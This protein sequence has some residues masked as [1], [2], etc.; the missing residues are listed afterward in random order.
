MR[1]GLNQLGTVTHGVAG[2]TTELQS[3]FL[4]LQQ[5]VA[6]E[7][8][9][10][11]YLRL[12]IRYRE[13]SPHT[14][15][16]AIFYSLYALAH[17]NYEV[18]LEYGLQAF[19]RRRVNLVVWRVLT[20]CYRQMHRYDYAAYFA[21]LIHRFCPGDVDLPMEQAQLQQVFDMFSLG[22]GIA[23]YAPIATRRAYM[24]EQGAAL[25]EDI[26]VGE[27]LPAV[28]QDD[29]ESY[30][31]G[32]YPHGTTTSLNM[33]HVVKKLR[34]D[35]EFIENTCVG[36]IFDLQRSHTT[37]T[38]ELHPEG[39]CIL[40]VATTAAGQR[41]KFDFDGQQKEIT[42]PGRWNYS[43]Y[44][45]DKD[46]RISSEQDMVVGQP[47]RLGHSPKRRKVIL[48]ILTDA[49]CWE[50]VGPRFA[51]LMPNTCRFFQKGIVF[52]KHYSVSE[53]TFPSL[54]TLE[55]GLY[56]A[57]S[58]VFNERCAVGIGPEIRTLAERMHEAGYYC[59]NL[60]SDGGNVYDGVTRGYDRLLIKSYDNKAYEGVSRTIVQLEALSECDQ[61]IFLH[62]DD[63]HSWPMPDYRV[64][65]ATQAHLPLGDR[66]ATQEYK[67]SVNIEGNI[68]YY[69]EG[70][71]HYIRMMD[72]NL[73][74]LYEYI[75]ANYSES[76]YVVQLYSDHGTGIYRLGTATPVPLL[77]SDYSNHAALMLRGSGIPARGR[78]SDE[79]T[80]TVDFYD[81][82]LHNAGL[83]GHSADGNLP[84][85]LGGQKRDF[86]AS[87]V[88]YPGQKYTLCLRTER[89][90]MILQ[91]R[92]PLRNDGTVNLDGAEC[93]ILN[94]DGSYG[95][96]DTPERRDYYMH[97]AG[98]IARHV[99]DQGIRWIQ[100]S[101]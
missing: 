18:A 10:D 9:D 19:A 52:D 6:Q 91:S 13:L 29:R 45:I 62:I 38:E 39:I 99:H 33:E 75:E 28:W 61:F 26:F 69:V 14:E 98:Y 49:L 32:I 64:G 8:Y 101:D 97:L 76:E 5:M 23:N 31:V 43:Y 46:T 36:T 79:L 78:V 58:Q 92:E 81:I 4:K 89:D 88:I 27:Y 47:I 73:E 15:H 93:R 100:G 41:L 94:R 82:T 66:L 87:Y 42:L 95:D 30:F 25:R 86:T 84:A 22:S 63:P 21:G 3:L 17:D 54:A 51:E 1:I 57:E 70:V 24:A 40:P 35:E 71:D 16:F 85:A 72:R 90:Q 68:P 37:R 67:A 34:H 77:V 83:E 80:S 20:A 74:V 11:D 2:N 53:Y 65:M 96:T 55:T 12:I 48:N 7:Q 56:P 60:M 59:M 50:H 44:R